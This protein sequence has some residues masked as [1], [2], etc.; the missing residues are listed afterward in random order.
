[1]DNSTTQSKWYDK[2]WLVI[3]LCIIFFPVGLYALWKNQS[4]SKGWKIGVTVVIALIVLAQ[5][6]KDKKDSSTSADN[7]SSSSSDQTEQKTEAPKGVGIGETLHTDYFD[8]TVNKVSLEDRVN[9]GNEFADLKPEQGNLYLIINASFKNTDKESRM[10]MD[11]SVWINY[12]GKNYEFDKAETVMLEGWGLLLDQINPLTT[13][14]TN[15]VYKIPAEIK[16][17]AYWQPGRADSD[18]KIFLGNLK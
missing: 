12:N 1:M 4:I 3:V 16:G 17:D 5:I 10:L 18:Q 7:S 13:K 9:T 14:T 15:L 8:I 6:G 11:G 2:T